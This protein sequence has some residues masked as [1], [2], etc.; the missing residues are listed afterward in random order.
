[1]DGKR[2]LGIGKGETKRSRKR[3]TKDGEVNDGIIVWYVRKVEISL[4]AT[5]VC[6]YATW[7][8]TKPFL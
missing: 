5:P 3:N 2:K 7:N 6:M 1:M 4:N 8:V